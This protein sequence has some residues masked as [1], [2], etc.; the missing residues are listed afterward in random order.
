MIK[1]FLRTPLRLAALLAVA[2][3]PALSRAA[4]EWRI[5]SMENFAPFNYA[6]AAGDYVGVD[7]EIVEAALAR[8]GVR[9]RHE[10]RSWARAISEFESGETDMLMQLSPNPERFA[11]LIMIGPIRWTQTVFAVRRDS[12]IA[13]IP[14]LAALSGR[15][16]GVVAA[17]FYSDAFRDAQ[18]F[19]RVEA[20]ND[21]INLR[22]LAAG[23]IE[24]AVGGRAT[25][26]HI[27]R[28]KGVLEDVR[29]LPTPLVV[30]P[31]YVAFP[32]TPRGAEHAVRFDRALEEMRQDGALQRI[33]DRY[34]S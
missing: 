30:N 33:I 19:T 31:R 25:M 11:T 10:P 24:L 34:D 29:F 23:R 17:F 4:E 22:R 18:G 1:A 8:A 7:V 13:D 3:A 14:D 5:G 26:A 9:A 15:T 12:E 16:V 27:A 20:Y 32:R 2:L 28:N 6:N 21:E